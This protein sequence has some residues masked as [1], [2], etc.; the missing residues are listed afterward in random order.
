M[1]K[2]ILLLILIYSSSAFASQLI[3][4]WK[5][6]GIGSTAET[7]T[8]KSPYGVKRELVVCGIGAFNTQLIFSLA[9]D[10]YKSGE[11]INYGETATFGVNSDKSECIRRIDIA[12]P[13]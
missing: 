8:I 5:V 10:L 6:V 13:E 7:I 2:V 3:K 1:K 11:V 4:G 12:K 9:Q